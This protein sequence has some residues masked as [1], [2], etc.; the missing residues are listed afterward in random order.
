MR[1]P[2]WPKEN[3]EG[4]GGVGEKIQEVKRPSEEESHKLLSSGLSFQV[5]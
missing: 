5:R 4:R 3:S 2:V 1:R